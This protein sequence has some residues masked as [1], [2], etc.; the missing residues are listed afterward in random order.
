M[1]MSTMCTGVCTTRRKR[2][3]FDAVGLS[4]SWSL[5][6]IVAVPTLMK[7]GEDAKTHVNNGGSVRDEPG[8]KSEVRRWWI[9]IGVRLT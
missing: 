7:H 2:V 6:A 5:L 3:Y 9:D 8:S 1:T 4:L